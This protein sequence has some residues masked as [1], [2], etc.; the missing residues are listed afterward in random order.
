MVR[1]IKVNNIKNK[2]I[3][4]QRSGVN[5]LVYYIKKKNNVRA[6]EIFTEMTAT[7]DFYGFSENECH[8]PR[9]SHTGFVYLNTP[10][11]ATEYYANE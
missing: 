9:L 7:V 10:S 1:G 5:H 11:K 2:H 4:P 8:L 6:F 3:K